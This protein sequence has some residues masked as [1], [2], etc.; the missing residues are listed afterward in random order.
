M[1]YRDD[2]GKIRELRGTLAGPHGSDA[3]TIAGDHGDLRV[4]RDR[5]VFMKQGVTLGGRRRN[6]A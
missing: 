2:D 6:K 5:I 3:V 4:A 1:E